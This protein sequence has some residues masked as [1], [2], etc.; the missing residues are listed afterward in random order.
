MLYGKGPLS[1]AHPQLHSRKLIWK[2]KRVPIKTTVPLKGGYLGFH[3]SLGECI[4]SDTLNGMAPSCP[5][6]ETLAQKGHTDFRYQRSYQQAPPIKRW[7]NL[8]GATKGK[9]GVAWSPNP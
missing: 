9:V 5:N 3:V 2:P 4:P 6:Q 8:N 7:V 1:S